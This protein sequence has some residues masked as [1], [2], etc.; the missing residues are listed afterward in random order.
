MIVFGTDG[1]RGVIARDFTFENLGLVAQATANYVKTLGD[2]P[3]V[4]VGYD[5][6]FLSAEFAEETAKILAEN[7]VKVF[8]SDTFS[9]TPQVSFQT[10][11]KGAQLGVVITASHNPPKYNG[12]K[13]KAHFGGPAVPE[14]IT[15]LEKELAKVVEN[16]TKLSLKNLDNYTQNGSITMFDAEADYIAHIRKNVDLGAI[17]NAGFKV[18]HDPMHG[19]GI[20]I[21]SKILSNVD[22]IHNE[23]NP[24]FGEVDHPE[25]IAECLQ[26]LMDK[27]R[28]GG[29][30][31]G[32]ATDGDAD[33]VGAVDE[34]G[35]FV[36]SHRIFVL[37]MKYLYED[38]GLR[39]SVAKTVSLTTMVNDYCTKNNIPLIETAVGFKY[40]SALMSTQ[41]ILIGGEESGGLGTSLHIPERDGVFNGLLLMEMMAVRKK[42]LKEL[43]DE[44]DEEFGTHRY[45]RRDVHVSQE[46]KEAIMGAAAKN[47]TQLGKY[48]VTK[49]DT[50][51]GFKF[52][53]DGGW[54]LI[55]ASGTEPLIRFYSEAE[56]ME[57]VDEILDAG[58]A[59]K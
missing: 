38:K 9:S 2:N 49:T 36:D 12:Y 18:L 47:P 17:Q 1:W 32:I 14:Q 10:K 46:Q 20:G 48:A 44:L 41:D 3:T 26:P 57:K 15:A 33:R 37:L 31:V 8:L 4:V 23:Y 21:L 40:I 51:D 45:R 58:L 55:R 5:T 19:A 25:P 42:S 54:L 35:N 59:L 43:C 30:A 13:L 11:H 50:R 29:Y 34:D 39:G 27:V 7:G 28:E 16:P 6:R 24:S 56:N 52:F 22:A 53:V